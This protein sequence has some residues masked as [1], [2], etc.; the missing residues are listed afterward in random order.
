MLTNFQNSFTDRFM[1][2]FATKCWLSHHILPV[3]LHYLIKYQCSKIAM[4]K[5]SVWSK[6]SWKTRPLKIA[7]KIPYSDFYWNKRMHV[8]KIVNTRKTAVEAYSSLNWPPKPHSTF[9]NNYRN[10]VGSFVAS[11]VYIGITQHAVL[12]TAVRTS[13]PRR[14]SIANSE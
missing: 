6:L 11:A 1:R 12:S 14:D 8:Y 2:K 5:T 13:N 3:L 10:V 7:V 9:M 4:L